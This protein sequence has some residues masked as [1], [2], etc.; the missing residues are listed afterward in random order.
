MKQIKNHQF[1]EGFDWKKLEKL[2]M[3]I[4]TQLSF[5]NAD[6]LG[7]IV[8]QQHGLQDADYQNNSIMINR[9]KNFTFAR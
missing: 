9:V 7:L 8:I 2:E 6:S 1:F 4:P 3:E 5:K